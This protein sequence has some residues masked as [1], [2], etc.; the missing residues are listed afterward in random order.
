MSELRIGEAIDRYVVEGFLGRGGMAVVYK[1]RHRD[2]DSLHALKVLTIHSTSI[3]K[4]LHQEGRAQAKLRHANIVSVTD[5]VD[6]NG[7]PGLVMECVEGPDLSHVLQHS[8]EN[9]SLADTLARGI[10]SGV[11][12]AHRLGFVHR[13]LKPANILIARQGGR[14]VPKITDF[15]LVKALLDENEAAARTQTGA[16][17]GTPAYMAPEQIRDPSVVDAR[18]DLFSLGVILYELTCGVRPFLGSDLIA[19]FNAISAGDYLHPQLRNPEIPERMARAITGAL[20]ADRD[21]R[22]PD[23]RALF[24]IWEGRV[25]DSSSMSS[26]ESDEARPEW[27]AL[28]DSA[29]A[30]SA[31]Q[32]NAMTA[33]PS[34]LEPSQPAENDAARSPRARGPPPPAAAV[35]PAATYYEDEAPPPPS[36]ESADAEPSAGGELPSQG[37]VPASQPPLG[38]PDEPV[39][40][41]R[42]PLPWVLGLGISLAVVVGGLLF[43]RD[44]DEPGVGE[45]D[46]AAPATAAAPVQDEPVETAAVPEPDEPTQ[47]ADVPEPS[48]L[49]VDGVALAPAS[50]PSAPT[51][52]DPDPAE[53]AQL[54][55]SH[56]PEPAEE[57]ESPPEPDPWAAQPSPAPTTATVESDGGVRVWLVSGGDRYPPGEIPPGSYTI[58]AFF[59]P[60]SPTDAGSFSAAAGERFVVKC[61]N[62]MMICTAAKQ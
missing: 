14:P 42:G 55:P 1:V 19:L 16:T 43:L 44:G 32:S 11:V 4:R 8:R 57:P 61:A 28:L 54:E 50:V 58:K 30:S 56:E 35:R 53:Q 41:P 7:A 15:G 20:E 38:D 48:S 62:A 21:K 13:D 29:W 49:S 9:L 12:E 36:E 34:S 23:C 51:S 6:V 39:A 25:M 31:E 5:L 18:A 22:I 46:A 10:I 40:S 60:L 52:A 59:D 3:R 33:V 26:E 27:A 45:P 24:E 47:P 37:V 2:L 17:M